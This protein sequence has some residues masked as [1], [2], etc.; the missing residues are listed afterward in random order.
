[1]LAAIFDNTLF[2]INFTKVYPNISISFLM[3]SWDCENIIYHYVYQFLR[4][5]SQSTFLIIMILSK[6][7][8][9]LLSFAYGSTVCLWAIRSLVGLYEML[10]ANELFAVTSNM[11]NRICDYVLFYQAGMM[12]RFAGHQIYNPEAQIQ[13]I[14]HI[15]QPIQVVGYYNQ[16]VPWQCV[17]MIPF[18]YLPLHGSYLLWCA[19]SLILGFCGLFIL[20]RRLHEPNHNIFLFF[21]GALATFPA[22][23][24]LRTG[25]SSWLILAASCFFYWFWINKNDIPAGIALAITT[26]K[27]Q[28]AIFL[29]IPVIAGL[30]TRLLISAA[31]TEMLFVVISAKILGW[32][33]IL[34]YPRILLNAETNPLIG[35]VRADL[36]VSLRGA[37]VL[38]FPQTSNSI[39]CMIAMF[40]SILC[41]F[42]VWKKALKTVGTAIPWGMSLT[43][44]AAL[45]FSPHTHVYDC[46]LLILPAALTLPTISIIKA[47]KITPRYYKW[48]SLML[49]TYPVTSWIIFHLKER[50]LLFNLGFI[51][52]DI[53]LLSLAAVNF[54]FLT[55][56]SMSN[57]VD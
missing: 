29:S 10:K 38:I 36:M 17:A 35:A 55:D 46:V 24:C 42:F 16:Y 32:D 37:L 54:K 30:K 13:W 56:I 23:F 14:N 45:I 26:I 44:L 28:Y 48:W 25:Q 33:N 41:L 53:C 50:F 20:R 22:V 21:L 5:N 15:V 40:V 12:A 31:I 18:T 6:S 34:N 11:G 19:L 7:W 4:H 43:I 1:M 52:V 9:N 2:L 51:L 27:P 8:Q 47:T 57:D 39:I 3:L 49:I